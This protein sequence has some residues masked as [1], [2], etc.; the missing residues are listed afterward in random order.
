MHVYLII[1]FIVLFY[2]PSLD[3]LPHWLFVM[4][5]IAQVV[6][7]DGL[8]F[9]LKLQR[10]IK[11][12]HVWVLMVLTWKNSNSKL[13]QGPGLRRLYIDIQGMEEVDW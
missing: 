2:L 8:H 9:T 4:I 10:Q 11:S 1:T 13:K 6:A 7:G 3:L 12:I 5:G